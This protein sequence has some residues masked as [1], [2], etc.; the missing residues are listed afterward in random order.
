MCPELPAEVLHLFRT[1]LFAE[2]GRNLAME[3]CSVI[4]AIFSLS[5]P[6]TEPDFV[7]CVCSSAV[8]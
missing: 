5:D 2:H 7:L 4:N 3:L 1:S 8:A 6:H